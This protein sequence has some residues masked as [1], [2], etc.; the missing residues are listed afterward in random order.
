MNK[1]PCLQI[2]KYRK[3]SSKL[4]YFYYQ[5]NNKAKSGSLNLGN[6]KKKTLITKKVKVIN[7]DF[8]FALSGPIYGHVREYIWNAPFKQRTFTILR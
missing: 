2:S 4:V 5:G 1:I 3:N 8:S 6:L 7:I